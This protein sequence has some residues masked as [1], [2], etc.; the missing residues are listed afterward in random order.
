MK[1]VDDILI[2]YMATAY[3]E[4]NNLTSL[5][6]RCL[7]S[8]EKAKANLGQDKLVFKMILLNNGSNDNTTEVIKELIKEDKRVIGFDNLK[9]YGPELSSGF[10]LNQ[11]SLLEPDYLIMLCSDLQDPPELTQ[12]MLEKIISKGDEYDSILAYKKTKKI[13]NLKNIAR[14][15]YYLILRFADRD[16]KLIVGFH[17]F[18]CINYKTMVK[19]LWY[20][21]NSN[22]NMRSAVSLASEKPYLLGYSQSKREHGESSYSLLKYSREAFEAIFNGKSFTS[23][24]ALRIG[25]SLFLLSSIIV[26]F[27]VVNTLISGTAYAAGIPT[28]SLIMVLGF[29]TQV[30]LLSMIS[31]QIEN[32]SSVSDKFN[33]VS[34]IKMSIDEK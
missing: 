16:S 23:R 1:S 25:L 26:I 5:Y 7:D 6:Y 20:L 3:N 19:T 9:N 30:I 11:A 12:L 18:G 32:L 27:V 28:V 13:N 15:L 10:G 29:A 33:K 24:I 34:S 17:G 31:R 8:F 14:R 4:A 22:L 2:I 21:K